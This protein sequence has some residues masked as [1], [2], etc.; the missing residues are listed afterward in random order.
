MSEFALAFADNGTYFLQVHGDMESDTPYLQYVPSRNVAYGVGGVFA[1]LI[2][3][4]LTMQILARSYAFGIAVLASS[5]L[6]ISQ[7]LR[8]SLQ[9]HYGWLAMYQAQL[10]L[11]TGGAN[12]LLAM[13]ML[14]LARWVEY[15]E[16]GRQRRSAFAVL[17]AGLGAAAAVGAVGLQSVGVPMAFNGSLRHTGHLLMI[18][19]AAT[20]LGCGGIGLLVAAWKSATTV[21]QPMAAEALGLVLPFALQTVWASFSLAQAKLPLDNVA[22]RSE[23]AFYLLNVLPLG[24]VLVLWTLINAPRLFSFTKGAVPRSRASRRWSGRAASHY[25][26][27]SLPADHDYSYPLRLPAHKQ[28]GGGGFPSASDEKLAAQDKVQNAI[29]KYA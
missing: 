17:L 12:L 16:G 1:A 28:G 11:N 27:P 15:L 7:F 26:Y 6:M 21:V 18:S 14:L 24:L 29:L 19:S 10:V 22:N 25:E 20:T 5:C 9:Q 4:T 23:V 3:A 2:L 8:G 13:G